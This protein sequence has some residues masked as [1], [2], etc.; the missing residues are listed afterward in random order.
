MDTVNV[1]A[2]KMVVAPTNQ[3]HVLLEI[4]VG[5][6]LLG[7]PGTAL[8]STHMRFTSRNQQPV[9]PGCFAVFLAVGIHA[10]LLPLTESLCSSSFPSSMGS[11]EPSESLNMWHR[12]WN[13]FSVEIRKKRGF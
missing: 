5:T 4:K 6:A 1:Q 13:W 3:I 9:M 8:A 12:G 2:E 11:L 7:A 10:F